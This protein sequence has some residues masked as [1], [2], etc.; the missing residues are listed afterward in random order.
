MAVRWDP[1]GPGMIGAATARNQSHN[2]SRNRSPASVRVRRVLGRLSSPPLKFAFRPQNRIGTR[3]HSARARLTGREIAV[4][5]PSTAMG[6]RIDMSRRHEMRL[7]RPFALSR[8][9]YLYRQTSPNVGFCPFD[10]PTPI[11]PCCPQGPGPG[12]A[13]TL[14]YIYGGGPRPLIAAIY[15]ATPGGS[16]LPVRGVPVVSPRCR[17]GPPRTRPTV[18]LPP[19]RP[20]GLSPGGLSPRGCPPPAT[21]ADRINA[22]TIASTTSARTTSCPAS[23]AI[24][25]TPSAESIGS[26]G[27]TSSQTTPFVTQRA[28][29][30]SWLP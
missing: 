11:T 1:T 2:P 13:V 16:I 9:R 10:I 19:P 18:S 30:R 24:L 21:T 15:I 29:I 6:N 4:V 3:H 28:G 5:R 25:Y 23:T 8:A 20:G 12:M 27:A 17:P 26:R 14:Q 7:P 22:R